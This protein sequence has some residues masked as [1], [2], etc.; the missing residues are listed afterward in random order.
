MARILIVEDD[1]HSR[2]Y[3]RTLLTASH[4]NVSEAGDGLEALKSA[5]A[6]HPDLIITDILMPTMDGF[7]FVR[8]LRKDRELAATRV[9]F[10][11]ATYLQRETDALAK[12]CGVTRTLIKPVEPNDVNRAVNEVLNEPMVQEPFLEEEFHRQHTG[13]VSDMAMRK[14]TELQIANNRLSAL[15]TVGNQLASESDAKQLLEKFCKGARYVLAARYAAVALRKGDE[16]KIELAATSG[17]PADVASLDPFTS[18]AQLAAK[19]LQ[20]IKK[21]IRIDDSS[22][23]SLF[24]ATPSLSPVKSCLAT[25]IASGNKLYGFLL[26]VGK[27]GQQD[28]NEEDEQVAGT[29]ASQVAVAYE[30]VLRVDRLR[31]EIGERKR[32]QE[33]LLRSEARNRELIEHATYGIYRSTAEGRFLEANEALVRILGYRSV[34]EVFALNLSGDVYR[35]PAERAQLVE[36][37]KK[38][39]QV[40]GVEVHWLKKDKTPILVRLSARNVQG[41][42]GEPECFEVFAENVT[43]LRALEK[44]NRQLQKFEAIGQ[45]AGGIAHDFNN[46]IGAILGWSELGQ[47]EVP[48]DSRVHKYLKKIQNQAERAAALTRQLLAFARRQILE[49]RSMSLNQSIVETMALLKAIIGEHIEIKLALASDLEMIHADPAQIEQVLLN[50]CVNA[51]DAMPAG[52]E[53]VIETKN[54][55]FDEEYCRRQPYARPGAFVLLG[56]SDTGHGMDN[57]T[58][59]RIF[60]PFFTTKELGK[61]TGLG[62]STVYG[63]VKQHGGFIHVYSEPDRGSTFRVHF[64]RT[65]SEIIPSE[66]KTQ[67]EPGRGGTETILVAE[68]QEA[69]LEIAKE[70]LGKLGY[71]VLC[72]A[73]GEAAVR[74]FESNSE[75]IALVLLDILMPKLSGPDAFGKMR[76]RKPELPVL[77]TTG[78]S[79]ELTRLELLTRQGAEILQKPYGLTVLGQRV[80]EILD[81]KTTRSE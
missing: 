61:G 29:L 63:V 39:G 77:F 31:M 5:Q 62:L 42:P 48:P 37:C 55:L 9:I 16:N 21:A 1:P 47:P 44:S 66:R 69:N 53:L 52:G 20:P 35:Y 26:A 3:L 72:A 65:L 49:P 73:D 75:R 50:L 57:A 67:T 12:S 64:P 24:A 14:S 36:E 68:D 15:I 78:Y 23:L 22:V 33:A 13:L 46:V 41:R 11:S 59:E 7:E 10:C 18:L 27:V 74:L 34:A 71:T 32:A 70:I 6:E 19:Q 58:L 43:E 51:R 8:Q 54:V 2:D 79:T 76:D 38:E 28:F 60:E 81:R 80:R 40:H 56:V 25:A 4:H 45:L 17:L 30:N